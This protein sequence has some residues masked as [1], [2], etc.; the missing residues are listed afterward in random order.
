[1]A[2]VAALFFVP[3]SSG[4][5]APSLTVTPGANSYGGQQTTW[6]GNI[7]ST[8]ER[9][10]WLQRRGNQTAAWAD[11]PDPQTGNRFTRMT[12]RDG[13][14]RF[15]FPAPAMNFV[16]FRVASGVGATPAHV[17]K[18]IHQ[19]VDIQLF[20]H[21]A[22]DVPLPQTLAVGTAVVGEP[23]SLRVDTAANQTKK[24]LPGRAVTLQRRT[25]PGTW[26]V[27][28][29]GTVGQNGVLSFGQYDG[30]NP[31]QEGTFRVRLENWA[32]NG[33]KVGWFLSTPF[34]VRFL[35][36]PEPVSS[37][38]ATPRATSF[39]LAWTLPVDAARARIVIARRIGQNSPVPTAPEHEYQTLNDR[40]ATTFTD[41]DVQPSTTY[42]YAVYTVSAQGIYTR[43]P[44]RVTRVTPAES[45]G[46]N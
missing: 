39:V 46:G 23:F 37:L 7:G 43:L 27:F 26:E 42:K 2:V 17:F 19:D 24:V 10:I 5:P 35:P 34:D 32:N 3:S 11:V 8:G 14:F 13:S 33:D 36:R 28:A 1:M 31:A 12:N 30:T 25:G 21:D 40:T 44:Q 45:G 20:E 4:A 22:A 6:T 16:Y 18:S 29:R 9:R 38:Q 15:T 41:T